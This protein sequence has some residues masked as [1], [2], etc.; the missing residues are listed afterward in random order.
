[1]SLFID[2]IAGPE[3]LPTETS[4]VLDAHSDEVWGVQFSCDGKWLVTA[5]KDGSALLWSI[6][7]GS[8]EVR[9]VR[10][11]FRGPHP[12]NVATFSPNASSVL[13]GSSD[14]RL[15]LFDLP[16][17]DLRLEVQV[18]SPSE[19]IA[20]ASWM[21][22]S[23]HIV[24]AINK[25]VQVLDLEAGG[26]LV[27]RVAM[28][29]HVY[30]VL[31]S[32]DGG[33]F[34]AAGQDRRLRYF[35]LEDRKEVTLG[36]EP[37][38]VTCLS[39]SADGR[40]VAANLANGAIHIWPVGDLRAPTEPPVSGS[41]PGGS[42]PLDALPTAPLQELRVGEGM[43]GRFVIRSAFGGAGCAFLA[44]GSESSHVHIWHRERGELLASLEGHSS[45]VNAI[46]WNP[47]NEHMLV[48][49]S[50][51][52]TLRVWHAPVTHDNN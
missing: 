22:D 32:K 30:D 40:F 23:R 7:D 38:S 4:Q 35:R 39:G 36:T 3:Q 51:D 24:I 18:A 16:N 25:E 19:G 45:T 5:S 43:P 20:A 48:S 28:G 33:T 42:D 12:V 50:D 29:Q 11:L 47:C 31:L 37:A 34:I 15:R 1:M 13:V 10:P 14:G 21:P 49:A 8:T 9:L 26:G 44:S 27:D 41:R 17:G 46:A 52:H 6:A 2:Y